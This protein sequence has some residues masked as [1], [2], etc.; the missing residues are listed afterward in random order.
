MKHLILLITISISI[1]AKSVV[2]E[3]SGT[4]TQLKFAKSS[5]IPDETSYARQQALMFAK[6]SA[7]EEAGTTLYVS[8]TSTT[9]SNGNNKSKNQ[10]KAIASALIKTKVLSEGWNANKYI[11]KIRATIDSKDAEDVFKKADK[12]LKEISTL[13]KKNELLLADIKKISNK[14]GLIRSS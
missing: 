4:Y 9:R 12:R 5:P 10:V 3:T 14:I 2:I 8:F 11:V 6:Q 7:V 13:Q 1:F